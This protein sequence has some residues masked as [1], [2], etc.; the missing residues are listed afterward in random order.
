MYSLDEHHSESLEPPLSSIDI[1][2]TRGRFLNIPYQH[3]DHLP[4]PNPSVVAPSPAPDHLSDDDVHPP[5]LAHHPLDAGHTGTDDPPRLPEEEGDTVQI[6]MCLVDVDE[7]DTGTEGT[8]EAD[9][10]VEE[11]QG[12]GTG[13]MAV[14]L[15]EEAEDGSGQGRGLHPLV[16][17]DEAQIMAEGG[18]GPTVLDRGRTPALSPLSLPVDNPLADPGALCR[19]RRTQGGGGRI[20]VPCPEARA[21]QDLPVPVPVPLAG[22]VEVKA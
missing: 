5:T 21:P 22:V 11:V 16:V 10:E 1:V 19:G 17:D 4:H 2:L 18:A 12:E 6:R 14:A 3:L 9:I 8:I 15:E 13:G 20:R 7:V